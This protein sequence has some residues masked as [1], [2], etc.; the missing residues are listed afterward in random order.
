MRKPKRKPMNFRFPPELIA[1]VDLARGDM[2]RTAFIEW[3]LDRY[4]DFPPHPDHVRLPDKE[5]ARPVTERPKVRP[6][7]ARAAS[8]VPGLKSARELALERQARMNRAK[9]L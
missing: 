9:G 8:V 7:A 6:G 2:N 4:L 5:P 3:A 1:R